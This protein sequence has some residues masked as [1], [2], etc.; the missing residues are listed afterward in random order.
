MFIKQK[1]H[2]K[3]VRKNLR[4]IQFDDVLVLRTIDPQ[5][6]AGRDINSL[7]QHLLILCISRP[8][9]ERSSKVSLIDLVRGKIED[10][11]EIF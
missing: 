7:A 9:R 3:I 4:K 11:G 5:V 10:H 1:N 8:R 6:N 2:A